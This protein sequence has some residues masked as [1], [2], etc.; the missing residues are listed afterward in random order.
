MLRALN[1]DAETAVFG[2]LLT[3][4]PAAT[5]S[6]PD[7][8]RPLLENLCHP[9]ASARVT[10]RAGSVLLSANPEET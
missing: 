7:G 5:L 4:T 8:T 10:R 1:T 3:W 2:P 6:T 9:G